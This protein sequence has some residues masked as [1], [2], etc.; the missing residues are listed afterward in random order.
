MANILALEP[1]YGGSHRAFL[2]GWRAHSRHGITALTLRPHHWK[3][4]MRHSALTFAQQVTS[5]GDLRAFDMIWCSSMVN[6]AEFLGTCPPALRG[7]PSAVYFHENQLAYP[8]QHDD[9]RDVHFAF[10]HWASLCAA[11]ELWFNS[12]YNQTSLLDGL[13]ALFQKMPDCR[14]FDRQRFV[15]SSFRLCPGIDPLRPPEARRPGALRIA[16]AAR[17]EHDKGP[18]LLLAA[19]RRF[20]A[21][22]RDFR[23][24]VLGEQFGATPPAM[25]QLK[26]E[27][28]EHLD[29]FGFEPDR[30][31]YIE[32]LQDADIFVST[33]QHEF[34]GLAVMEA[35]ACGCSLL[36]PR[37]LCYPELFD[38]PR[39]TTSVSPF[40]D[41]TAEGLHAALD[42]LA[43]LPPERLPR[44]ADVAHRYTWPNRALELDE[45]VDRCM[46]TR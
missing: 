17:F 40:Y 32:H 42:G 8:N 1:Y 36:L 23:L 26:A 3:W 21:S 7:L 29:H 16:W 25:A 9:P 5:L 18:D 34:F 13:A 2:D 45:A 6:L 46:T 22:H 43:K 35:A 20:A 44:Y 39:A 15:A 14:T 28:G 41:N 4:R 27:F 12:N 10:T 33:S 24:T 30:A 38:V 11:T 37:R 31:R 19:L